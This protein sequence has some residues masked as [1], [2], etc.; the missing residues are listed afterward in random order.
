MPYIIDGHNLIPSAPGLRLSDPDDEARLV[1]LL[2]SFCARKRTRVTVY[3]DRG[4]SGTQPHLGGG[5]VTV[6][7]VRPPRTA[8]DAIAAHLSRL[9]GEARNWTVVSSDGAVQR[10][11]RRAGARALTS[12]SFAQHLSP[13]GHSRAHEKPEPALSKEEVTYWERRFRDSPRRK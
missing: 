6:R 13:G 9:G 10:A 8:D 1:A 7:F 4:L 11:A 12:P 3:F 2:R 5:G